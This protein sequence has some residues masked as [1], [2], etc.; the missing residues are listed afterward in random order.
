MSELLGVSFASPSS[1]IPSGY[2]TI[3]YRYAKQEMVLLIE[4]NRNHRNL[5]SHPAGYDCH[6]HTSYVPMLMFLALAA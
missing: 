2:S 1:Q 3:E 5:Q 4:G 6:T